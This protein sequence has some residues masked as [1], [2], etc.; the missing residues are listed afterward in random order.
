MKDF[1]GYNKRMKKAMDYK[2]FWFDKVDPTKFDT[3][4]DFG[5]GPGDLICEILK[6]PKFK[7]KQI[8]GYDNNIDMIFE[9]L[10][11]CFEEGQRVSLYYAL[12]PVLDLLKSERVLVIF[13][14]VLHEC[15]SFDTL[16][17]NWRSLNCAY[18]VIRDMRPEQGIKFSLVEKMKI[19]DRSRKKHFFDFFKRYGYSNESFLHFILKHPYE[20]NWDT[21]V[22][23]NYFSTPWFFIDFDLIGHQKYEIDFCEDYTIPF[24]QSYSLRTFGIR[25]TFSTHRSILYKRR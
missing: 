10:S 14:S 3:I 23:E 13:S 24:I 17:F 11:N 19:F 16:P 8:V 9:G 5:C 6:E 21:E 22:K 1:D 25:Y 18:I 4:L 2:T 15:Y 20:E 7:D 12:S